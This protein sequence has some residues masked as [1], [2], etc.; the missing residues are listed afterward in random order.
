M[1]GSKD[2]VG[3]S[4]VKLGSLKN[5]HAARQTR[6]K[7]QQQIAGT[8]NRSPKTEPQPDHTR[9]AARTDKQGMM[10]L[11]AQHADKESQVVRN[12]PWHTW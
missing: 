7:K 1:V 6:D 3:N 4:V 9:Q 11:R 2:N 10:P 5:E 8:A 12:T